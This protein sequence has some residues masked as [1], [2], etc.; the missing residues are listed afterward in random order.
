MPHTIV[1]SPMCM[2]SRTCRIVS[3][4]QG[5]PAMIPV[6]SDRKSNSANRGRSSSAMNMVGTP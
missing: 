3:T 2:R 5:E 1:T 4:G 6:R